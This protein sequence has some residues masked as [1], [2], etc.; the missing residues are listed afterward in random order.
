MSLLCFE[1]APCSCACADSCVAG[2]ATWALPAR[3]EGGEGAGQGGT[4]QGGID[5]NRFARVFASEL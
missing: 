1:L 5:G 4:G 3:G 2:K